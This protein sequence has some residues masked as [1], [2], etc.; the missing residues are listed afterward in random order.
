M[1]QNLLH[2]MLYDD[3]VVNTIKDILSQRRQTISVAE[4]VTAGH[5][6]AA[7]SS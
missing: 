6:Q 1:A 2:F 7:L 5:L 3:N 4:S